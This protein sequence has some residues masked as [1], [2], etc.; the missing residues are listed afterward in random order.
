[1][2]VNEKRKLCLFTAYVNVLV[3]AVYVRK[4]STMTG[5]CS[6]SSIIPS[7][8][9][10]SLSC[11]VASD[12]TLISPSLLAGLMHRCTKRYEV[13]AG[14]YQDRSPELLWVVCLQYRYETTEAKHLGLHQKKQKKNKAPPHSR[15]KNTLRHSLAKHYEHS[16]TE[17]EWDGAC[18]LRCLQQMWRNPEMV[19]PSFNPIKTIST[20]TETIPTPSS[21]V[22]TSYRRKNATFLWKA[23]L[24]TKET[25][26]EITNASGWRKKNRQTTSFLIAWPWIQSGFG[27]SPS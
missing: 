15:P 1:M 14:G 22:R 4:L 17:W 25:Q 12:V 5:S 19:Y 3:S 21:E 11:L 16:D 27:V 7:L 6:L 8:L 24:V 26:T 13:T 10:E 2:S 23:E 20:Q 9:I 18:L